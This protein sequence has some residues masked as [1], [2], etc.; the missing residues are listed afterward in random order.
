MHSAKR[1]IAFL[2]CAAL[3]AP[4]ASAQDPSRRDQASAPLSQDV[5]I[6]IQHEQV[7]FTAQKAIEYMQLQVFNQSGELVY[8]SGAVSEPEINWPF[9]GGNG[10]ALKSGLYAY[11]LT[12]KEVGVETAR[13]RR[14]HFIVDRA[15][16]QDGKTD[17]LWVTSKNDSGVGAELTVAGSE[18]E[19]VAGVRTASK[20][21]PSREQGERKVEDANKN[22]KKYGEKGVNEALEA[23]STGT[24]GQLAKFTSSTEV[25]NSVMT[26]VNGS[27]GIGTTTPR[28][29]LSISGG[30]PWTTY[31]WGGAIELDNASAIGWT[32]NTA[33]NRFG[34]GQT[35]GGLSFFRTTSDPGTVVSPAIY[36][37][38]INDSGNVGIGATSPLGRLHIV[39]SAETAGTALFQPN[40]VKGS[41]SSHVHWGATGDWYIRSAA[42][43]GKVILQDTG[44]H[45]GIGTANITSSTLTIEGQDALAIRGYE[46]VL[47]LYDSNSGGHHII[48]SA[49]GDLNFFQR[50]HLGGATARMVIKDGG[51]VGI[52]TSYPQAKL[53]IVGETR[54]H[55]LQITGGADFAENFDINVSTT[56]SEAL[57]KVEPGMVVSIDPAHPGKLQLSSQAYDRRV[58]GIISGAGDVRPGMMMG[59]AGTLASGKHPVA[60]S[61][62]VYCWVDAA[63]GAIKPGDLLTTSA[64]PGHAMKATNRARAQG[65]IIGKAMTGLK[66]GKGLVLALVTLQ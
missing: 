11:T 55:S 27:I 63:Y 14:G 45:V 46:P 12:I 61:G 18:D 5:L 58:A 39:G 65:A 33:G 35:N 21:G 38:T 56:T 66:E 49:H 62:R 8:G 59:Q 37:L 23:A 47:H 64:T 9:Q 40:P 24:A 26:E 54:T 53:D 22:E 29:R 3:C 25:G 50:Y 7:R 52:G 43:S 48:Q 41:N 44:G 6:I 20:S 31:Y 32:A 13:A 1:F 28:H 15:K 19:T 16:E 30:L 60:L 42:A 10:E 57:A 51:N 36:D 2:L 4:I 34:I 17:R